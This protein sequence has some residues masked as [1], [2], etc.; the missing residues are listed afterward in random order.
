MSWLKKLKFVDHTDYDL[1]GNCFA[2]AIKSESGGV[3][4][5]YRA[6]QD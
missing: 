6:N 2:I 4:D 3:F 5:F 1:K